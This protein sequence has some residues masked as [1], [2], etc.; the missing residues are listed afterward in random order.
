MQLSQDEEIVRERVLRG[1]RDWW[2]L[3]A[4]GTARLS[5][6]HVS[7]DGTVLPEAE[8]SLRESGLY[9][10]R[11]PAAYALTVLTSTDCNLGCDYCFQNIGHDPAGGTR[12]PRIAHARLAS[13]TITAILQFTDRQMAMAG[14]DRLHLTLFG[15]EPLLNPRGCLELLDRAGGHGMTSA[16]MVSNLT[17]LTRPLAERLSERGLTSV[18]VTFDGDRGDH[19]RIRATRS[20]GATFDAIVRNICLASEITPLRWQLRVNIG[21]GNHLGVD[22]LIDRLA[23]ALDSSRCTLYFAPVAVVG[24]GYPDTGASAADHIRWHRRAIDAG[25]SVPRPRAA[26]ACQTCGHRDGRY[27]AVVSA[28]GTLSSCW[29]TAGQAGWEV[30]MVPDGYRPDGKVG[31]RWVTCLGHGRPARDQAAAFPGQDSIDAALLDHLSEAGRL[32]AATGQIWVARTQELALWCVTPYGAWN[33]WH[34]SATGF[35][36]PARC[37]PAS[38]PTGRRSSPPC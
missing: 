2:F 5:P 6:E 31:D 28:D 18:Q 9:T 22:A 21:A 16:S 32:L 7:Q 19:D 10:R 25:F 3:G 26:T 38:P 30:G 27:G 13:D 34:R 8:R 1:R 23:S 37:W 4:G 36:R 14:L 12:P 24:S 15:G 20:G 35:S 29:E 17:L 11:V 33:T